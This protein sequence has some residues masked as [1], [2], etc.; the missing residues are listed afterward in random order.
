LKLAS[1]SRKHGLYGLAQWYLKSVRDPLFDIN[2]RGD[3][4]TL[5]RFRY[6]YETNKLHMLTLSESARQQEI[7]IEN[8]QFLECPDYDLWMHAEI[9]RLQG[10][11]MMSKGD[12]NQAKTHLLASINK[13]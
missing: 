9:L 1:V 8:N 11:F 13:N 6:T 10:E 12:I 3:R 5:E 4:L 2:T 7:M